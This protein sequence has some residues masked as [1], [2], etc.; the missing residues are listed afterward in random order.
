MSFVRKSTH[1]TQRCKTAGI[2]SER[3]RMYSTKF[4]KILLTNPPVI[5][6]CFDDG[7]LVQCF[8]NYAKNKRKT[9]DSK[10]ITFHPH[11]RDILIR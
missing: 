1:S 3:G 10:S 9:K 11:I 2:R 7:Y 8:F 5:S 4:K 6:E